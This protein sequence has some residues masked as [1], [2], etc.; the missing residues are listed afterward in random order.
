MNN[1]L[2]RRHFLKL[3]AAIGGASLIPRSLW[4]N[5]VAA[6]SWWK[7]PKLPVVD[8]TGKERPFLLNPRNGALVEGKHFVNWRAKGIWPKPGAAAVAFEYNNDPAIHW[9]MCNCQF[10]HCSGE[11]ICGRYG[12]EMQDL[13]F[14]HCSN[15]G[16]AGFNVTSLMGRHLNF[17]R[18]STDHPDILWDH[19][20]AIKVC[21][22]PREMPAEPFVDLDGLRVYDC[23]NGPYLWVDTGPV[24]RKLWNAKLYGGCR[25]R[26]LMFECCA[27]DPARTPSLKNIE[28]AHTNHEPRFTWDHVFNGVILIMNSR[29]LTGENLTIVTPPH[30]SAFAF[31]DDDER[32]EHGYTAPNA[33]RDLDFHDGLIVL[34]GD[35]STLERHWWH[36]AGK[37]R[38][39]E[40][41]RIRDFEVW[42]QADRL[43]AAQARCDSP[44]A[45]ALDIRAMSAREIDVGLRERGQEHLLESADVHH[46]G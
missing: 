16:I 36:E 18:V 20:G 8:G 14:D 24:V 21:A 11:V 31:Q 46:R 5:E 44:F 42:V 27:G 45:D 25:T 2:P 15:V 37:N 4:A 10:S 12:M 41:I 26:G 22:G 38:V 23:W 33:T 7:P 28:I 29:D 17:W 43:S 9:G 13:W 1:A 6:P 34:R 32:H 35:D 40:N 30:C 19:C 3:T 39:G